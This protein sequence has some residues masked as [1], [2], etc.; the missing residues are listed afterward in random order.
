MKVSKELLN[1]IAAENA[2]TRAWI[3]EDPKN[4]WAGLYPETVKH[5]ED[6]G[7]FTLAQLERDELITHIYEGHKDAYGTKGRHYDF[8]AM[9]L[10]QLK[11]E[12]DSISVAISAEMERMEAQERANISNFEKQIADLAEMGASR[13]DAIRWMLE[14]EGL[15]DEYDVGYVQ[16]TF[17]LPYNYITEEFTS[18]LKEAA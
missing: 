7:I 1:H 13:K 9:S 17:G 15:K 10:E 14:A 5:W 3:A 18:A 16:Y 2:K 12:A 4:R 8:D 6:R 11:A